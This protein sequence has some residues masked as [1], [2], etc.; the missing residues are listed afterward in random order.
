MLVLTEPTR[1]RNRNRRRNRINTYACFD[2][3]GKSI[4][5]I[6]MDYASQQPTLNHRNQH[7]KASA[8]TACA[9]ESIKKFSKSSPL[10]RTEWHLRMA[11][12]DKSYT[13]FRTHS[14]GYPP[15]TA[16]PKVSA[17]KYQHP[18]ILILDS[19]NQ[20]LQTNAWRRSRISE[21]QWMLSY[22]YRHG[23]Q[24]SSV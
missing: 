22:G 8:Q 1:T 12:F 5:N 11:H 15:A 19:K 14:S 24:L 7:Q 16:K 3:S 23:Q 10:I 21:R 20:T 18:H 13:K 9:A 2:N 17:E 6:P 4:E